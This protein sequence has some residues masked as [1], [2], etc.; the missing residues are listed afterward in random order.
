MNY[1]GRI[2]NK[3]LKRTALIF[4]GLA[5]AFSLLSGTL[6]GDSGKDVTRT[7]STAAIAE[8]DSLGSLYAGLGL[9]S[10]GLSNDAYVFALKGYRN[11]LKTGNISRSEVLSIVDFSLPSSEKR[12]FVID[13]DNRKLIFNT[14]VSHG[15]NSGL[16]QATRFSNKLNSFQSS[17]GFYRTGNTYKG[18]HG[19]SLRLD[20]LEQG[21]N[22]NAFDRGIVIHAANYVN[23]KYALKKGFI[24]R[25][26]GCPAVPVKLHRPIIEAIK[27]GSCLFVFGPDTTYMVQSGLMHDSSDSLIRESIDSLHDRQA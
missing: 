26:L 19:Y 23:E 3:R 4:V 8:V 7:D 21:I 1:L 14:Y 11:L 13:M 5:S 17:L 6:P 15:R 9:D 24:G 18:E 10:L 16:E 22:D 27:G 25:S 2:I 12:L 20:G